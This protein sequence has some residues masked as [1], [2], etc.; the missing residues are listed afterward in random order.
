MQTIGFGVMNFNASSG[1][2][3]TANYAEPKSIPSSAYLAYSYPGLGLPGTTYVDVIALLERIQSTTSA[4]LSC[5]ASPGGICKLD[6]ACSSYSELWSYSFYLK[7]SD[8]DNYIIAPLAAL[9]LDVDNK[10]EL[11]ISSLD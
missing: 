3:E 1:L 8:S 5:D 2:P 11:W 7:F 9:A 10:C 6:N 4:Q